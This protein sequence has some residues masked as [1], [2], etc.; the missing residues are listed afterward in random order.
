MNY[1]YQKKPMYEEL[2]GRLKVC[3][4]GLVG[5]MLLILYVQRQLNERMD[6][7]F[8]WLNTRTLRAQEILYHPGVR[9][10]LEKA[11]ADYA[12]RVESGDVKLP[13]PAVRKGYPHDF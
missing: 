6:D 13:P 8:T 4:F 3:G 7:S 11:M 12:T 1:D 5:V 9:E 2:D 10:L